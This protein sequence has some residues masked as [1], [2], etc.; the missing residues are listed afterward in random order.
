MCPRRRNTE[1]GIENQAPTTWADIAASSHR[2]QGPLY[3]D[4]G[5]GADQHGYQ[6][7]PAEGQ[8]PYDDEGSDIVGRRPIGE[9]NAQTHTPD[10]KTLPS[11]AVTD[12]MGR[13][14][15]TGRVNPHS[16]PLQKIMLDTDKHERQE[17]EKPT[18]FHVLRMRQRRAAR[19][20]RQ[21]QDE[22]GVS[23]RTLPSIVRVYNTFQAEI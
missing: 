5:E 8:A 2:P 16:A 20:I 6:R 22:H 11:V 3:D 23:H 17:G 19:L 9:P 7:G 14:P 15:I 13:S 21:V 4:K 10:D 1:G 12:R 18:L